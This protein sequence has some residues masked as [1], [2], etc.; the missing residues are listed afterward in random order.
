MHTNVQLSTL[1]SKRLILRPL[2]T[3]DAEA[4]TTL[5]QDP[6]IA[7]WT[8]RLPW[9]YTLDDARHFIA[10]Q[11][12]D[13]H[14]GM[15]LNWG[16]VERVSDRLTG[17][18]GLHGIDT[19]AGRA[20]LGYWMGE[21]YR[22]KGYTTEAARRIVSWAFETAGFERIQATYFVGNDASATIMR[23]IGMTHEGLLR[24]Y[25]RKYDHLHDVHLYAVLR[26]DSSWMSTKEQDCR[27]GY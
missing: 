13:E 11:T 16:I 7:R 3:T 25:A 21:P 24:G 22:G 1:E 19:A 10:L 8:L 12:D 15:A 27:N 20:E 23:K 2:Q 26:D 17:V 14:A 6:V 4:M 9:P 18:V 5:L